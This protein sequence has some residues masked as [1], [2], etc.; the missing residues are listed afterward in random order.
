M[1]TRFRRALFWVLMA[2]SA[3]GAV[4]LKDP[5]PLL[6]VFAL[7][8]LLR[9]RSDWEH[10]PKRRSGKADWVATALAISAFGLTLLIAD[11][12][13]RW[14]VMA[15]ILIAYLLSLLLLERAAVA[16]KPGGTVEDAP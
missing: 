13:F 1:L 8:C 11:G 4:A 2:V 9:P 12:L 10:G 3:V 6:L 16:S 14:A 7:A 5:T 15:A